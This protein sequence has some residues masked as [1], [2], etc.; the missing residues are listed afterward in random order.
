MTDPALLNR[1]PVPEQDH[2]PTSDG[3][4]VDCRE[5]LQVLRENQA[6]LSQS[7]RD[8]FD[9]AVLMGVDPEA[10]RGILRS[11]VDALRDPRH[12]GAKSG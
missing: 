8:C 2:W 5:K 6:E 11:M 7:L 3:S 1:S 4:S 12:G 9:D 10:M